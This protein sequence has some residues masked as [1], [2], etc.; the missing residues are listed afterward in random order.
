MD[1]SDFNELKQKQDEMFILLTK[2]W[3]A[4]KRRRIYGF[5]KILLWGALFVVSYL[6]LQ[7]LLDMFLPLFQQIQQIQQ[8]PQLP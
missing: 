1:Q 2:L 5:L 6:A 3:R 4:E 7:P 8:L